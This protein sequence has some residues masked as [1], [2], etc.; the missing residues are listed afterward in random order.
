MNAGIDY[1]MGRTNIDHAMG[2]HYGVIWQNSVCQALGD[3]DLEYDYGDPCC[4]KCGNAA[5][6][7]DKL[8]EESEEWEKA[9]GAC[10]DWGCNSCEYVFDS[11]EAFGDEAIG[12]K[13]EADGY[14]LVNCLD[15]D[16]MILASE[17]YTFAPF[18]SPCVP[19][20]GNL[21]DARDGGVKTY[22]LGHDWFEDGKAPYPVFS[23]AT[24]A[25]VHPNIGLG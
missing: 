21:D 12:W 16:V 20:A 2:I 1:G 22:C 19:G 7:S 14:S 13:Y 3:S 5:V 11:S 6:E 23:V 4:P 18:C 24:G 9:R 10:S 17:F 25:E 15:N 8:P